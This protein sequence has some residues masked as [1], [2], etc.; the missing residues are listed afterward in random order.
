MIPA[1]YLPFP[2]TSPLYHLTFFPVLLVGF[3]DEK[4]LRCS[5]VARTVVS[6]V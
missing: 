5:P 1:I 6:S 2:A 4:S 3:F